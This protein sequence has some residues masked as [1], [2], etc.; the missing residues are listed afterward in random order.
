[1]SHLGLGTPK[2]LVFCTLISWK[3]FS[4]ERNFFGK[5]SGL[6]VSPGL[7]RNFCGFGNML[8]LGFPLGPMISVAMGSWLGLVDSTR[9]DFPPIEWPLGLIA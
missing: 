1:M 2:L 4:K 8:V 9:P 6:Y 3:V 5:M 7:R